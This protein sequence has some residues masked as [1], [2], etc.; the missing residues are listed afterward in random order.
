MAGSGIAGGNDSVHEP[1]TG[2]WIILRK[3]KQLV[4]III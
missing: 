4:Y 2:A 1:V 3:F